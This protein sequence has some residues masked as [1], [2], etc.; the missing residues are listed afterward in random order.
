MKE[1]PI[2]FNGKM[3]R[4]IIANRKHK[5]RRIMKN[6][7]NIDPQT[8]DWMFTNSNGSQEVHPI[9]QWIE[10]QIKLHC[11]YGKV[12]D[13]LWVRETFGKLQDADGGAYVY[14]ANM[15]D[16]DGEDFIKQP[17]R[18]SIFMPRNACRI[19]LEITDIRVERLAD[20]SEEDAIDE[21][22]E[23]IVVMTPLYK[24]YSKHKLFGDWLS[25]ARHSFLTLWDSINGR[26]A[27]LTNPWV[28]VISFKKV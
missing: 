19:L 10:I 14:R 7:P 8:G 15:Q 20:I 16:D 26:G 24:N 21:G 9:E 6:Q 23:S 25:T 28:W 18:P 12:G 27:S 22:I 2:L 5:T 4:A 3:V 17:W 11:P 13:R 1:R